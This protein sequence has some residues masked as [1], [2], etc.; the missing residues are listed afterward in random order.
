MG[1]SAPRKSSSSPTPAERDRR[2]EMPCGFRVQ[3]CVCGWVRGSAGPA[4]Y[5][6]CGAIPPTQAA[7]SSSFISVPSYHEEQ[8]PPLARLGAKD[9]V[10]RF[11]EHVLDC[12]AAL[13]Y[14]TD[15]R[16]L[17]DSLM[18]QNAD[19]YG[20][21]RTLCLGHA[22]FFGTNRTRKSPLSRGGGT[23]PSS[24]SPKNDK[25]RSK[26]QPTNRCDGNTVSIVRHPTLRL[27]GWLFRPS[28]IVFRRLTTWICPATPREAT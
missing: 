20:P 23:D 8:G 19:I 6:S 15:C 28:F 13:F 17:V 10:Q 3:M 1:C 12:L 4:H 26:E 21:V 5:Q 22:F 2:T 18:R 24:E 25:R 7:P 27:V 11:A 14:C 16:W 9:G